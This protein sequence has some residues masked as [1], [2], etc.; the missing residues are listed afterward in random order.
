MDPLFPE[1]PESLDGL[2][3][4]ELAA[5]L[6]ASVAAKDKIVAQDA[7]FLGEL[8]AQEIL[9]A[10]KAGVAGI[11]ALKAEQ[12]VRIEAESNLAA[13][14]AALNAQV[15]P[16]QTLEADPADP[17]DA[18]ELAA[19]NAQVEPD[20]TLEADPADPDAAAD[21][22]AV[23]DPAAEPVVAAADPPKPLRRLPAAGRHQAITQADREEGMVLRASAGLETVG[24]GKPLDEEAL[25]R[26]LVEK[27]VRTVATAPGSSERVVVARGEVGGVSDFRRLVGDGNDTDRK[28]IEALVASARKH[29]VGYDGESWG[30]AEALTASGGICAPVAPYYQLAYIS[31]M[32]RPVRDSLVGF[33][34]DRGGIRYV[35]PPFLAEITTGVGVISAAQ[36]KAGGSTGTK[37][38]QTLICPASVEVDVNSIFHCFEGGNL[39]Q[40][41][42]PEQASQFSQ[43]IL[44]QHA[45]VAETA[46]L[47][48][49]KAG[50][51]AV[52][53]QSSVLG[54]IS[55]LLNDILTAAAAYRSNNR[56]VD[57]APLQVI[58]PAWT[59]DLLVI[60]LIQSQF[61]RFAYN[62]D[63]IE[64]LLGTFNIRVTYTLDGP[65]DGLGQV[66]GRQAVGAMTPLPTKIEWPLF[67]P[68]AWLFVDSGVLEIG[69]VRDSILNATNSYQVFGE[70]WEAAAGIGVQSLWVT[71]TVCPSGQVAATADNASA[72]GRT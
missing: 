14:L 43:L 31:T 29:G 36:D 28:K 17:A 34:A 47:D 60:D 41:A 10:M 48:Q 69:I 64:Q 2:T 4:E 13:E 37:T 62:Q 33:I 5:H 1:L 26:A 53:G 9:E 7:E 8:S 65:S 46:L 44:T 52:T 57:D 59:G 22:A 16:D 61:Q 6:A 32:Q 49:I 66:L 24:E 45:R 68:G 71:S 15:E 11:L 56:M 3:D 54:A 27:I 70:S 67:H 25:N 12:A 30:D 72:C 51:T 18:A 39:G 42:F 20:Q 63:G 35:P 55:S 23:V 38:C 19:L 21:P 40:R 58:L 50:S